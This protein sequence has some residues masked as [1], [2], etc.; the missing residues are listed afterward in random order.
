MSGEIPVDDLDKTQARAE[1]QRLAIAIEKANTA[2]HANDDPDI[3]DA[4]Y[5]HLKRRNAEIEARF[6]NLKQEDSPSERVGAKPAEGFQKVT[7]SI[8]ML[9]L[10]NAFSSDDIIDF[11]A[12]IRKFLGLGADDA[13]AYTAEPKIDGLSLSVR[14]EKGKLVHA[15]TRGDGKVG[16]NVTRNAL[17]I[18]DIP[19][20][21]ADAPDLLEVRGEVYMSHED[22]AALNERQATS[23][24]KQFANPRNA[25]AGSLRQLDASITAS[26]PL[27]FLA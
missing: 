12:S 1:L 27:R 17:T 13:L 26:R 6:P 8:S 21:L 10:G 20:A 7:H 3:S 16:E 11:D 2:Y 24:D 22:F 19:N 18:S 9:S 15:A 23:G 14:Y 4:E 25:A 5:D